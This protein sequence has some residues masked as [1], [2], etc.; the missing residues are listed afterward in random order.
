MTTNQGS[1][2]R[3]M[4]GAPLRIN[5]LRRAVQSAAF[6]LRQTG[7]LCVDAAVDT[8]DSVA[9]RSSALYITLCELNSLPH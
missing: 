6:L 3:I 8:L 4:P 2:V 1:H 7:D 9:F 5:D